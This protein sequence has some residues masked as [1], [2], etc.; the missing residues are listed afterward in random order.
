MKTKFKNIET[1]TIGMLPDVGDFAPNFTLVDS[2]LYDIALEDFLGTQLI[3]NIFPSLDTSVCAM[4]VRKFNSIVGNIKN[5]SVLCISKDLPF[6]QKRF[7]STE[8]LS[9]VIT[10]SD[11]RP[12]STFG[13]DYG[14]MI[15]DGALRGLFARAILVLSEN[16]KVLYSKLSKEITEEPNYNAVLEAIYTQ[17]ADE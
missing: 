5:T 11:C 12:E 6:A 9:K 4:S 8:G 2:N 1:N 15:I 3:L 13:K 14:V 17:S 7:C 16:G 10:L